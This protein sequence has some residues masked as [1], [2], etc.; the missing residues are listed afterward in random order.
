MEHHGR[1]E[2]W[3]NAPRRLA[4]AL[5]G[6]TLVIA[7]IACSARGQQPALVD[8]PPVPS[9]EV[10]G[11]GL[12]VRRIQDTVEMVLNRAA[13]DSAF[14]GAV[15]IVGTRSGILARYAVGTLNWGNSSAPDE[16]TLWDLASL[17][18]V[19]ALTSAVM[20]LSQQGKLD[21][22][23]PV[24]RYLPEWRGPHKDRVRVKDLLTHSSGM[25]SW[26][27]LYKE[28]DTRAEALRLVL[29]TPLDTTPGVRMVYSDLGAILLGQIVERVSGVPLDRYVTRHILEPLGM[30]ETMFRPSP[31]LQPRIAPTEYDPWRQRHVRGEVHDENAFRLDGVSAHAGLFSTAADLTQIARMYLGGGMLNG[32]RVLDSATIV[33]FT[34]AE[35]R[36]FSHRALGWETANGANSGGRR[37]SPLAFGH[38]GFTGTS[39]WIDPGRDV[40]VILLT[41]RVNPT[42]ENRRIGGVRMALADAVMALVP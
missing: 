14:P 7:V 37:M 23:A 2:P 12:S 6:A 3:G 39:I 33:R 16:R 32:T 29:S 13:R 34:R 26:R 28:T 9:A 21:V 41:N 30:R 19:I 8:L 22:E 10:A 11:R 25:P 1:S 38:T 20:H 4:R 17:T 36:A 27:P 15:A 5:T 18:K 40:F 24:Q 31:Q 35:N 42:R